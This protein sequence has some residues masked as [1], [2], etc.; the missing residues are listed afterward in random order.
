[1]TNTS[2]EVG[3]VLGI[4]LL[5]TILFSKLSAT[6]GPLLAGSGLSAAQQTAIVEQSGHGAVTPAF[7]TALGLTPAQQ[8]GVYEA[9][10]TSYM[11]GFHRALFVGSVILLT[12]AFV[13]NRF[14]PGRDSN[15]HLGGA[16]EGERVPVEV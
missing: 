6:I 1:M 8:A 16:P 10:Q 9:F 15:V 11:A 14:I 2:R 12:A 13:A 7:L 4:A 5:G 3:G